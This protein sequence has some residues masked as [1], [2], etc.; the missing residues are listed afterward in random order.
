M[1]GTVLVLDNDIG[2]LEGFRALCEDTGLDVYTTSSLLDFHSLVA[3]HNPDLILV[4]INMP[5]LKGDDIVSVAR[6]RLHSATMVL[7]SG[8]SRLQ[9]KELTY[10]SGADGFL[11][12]MDEP[13]EILRQVLAWVKERRR[14]RG[15]A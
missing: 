13:D 2:V 15:H 9:L 6:D 8:I 3:Q 4:D 12:K 11:S 7:F 14:L 5:G 1:K 10:A